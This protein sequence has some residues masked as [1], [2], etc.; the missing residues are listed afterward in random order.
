[1]IMKQIFQVIFTAFLFVFA[2][3]LVSAC[4]GEDEFW[5][6]GDQQLT[7]ESH[8]NL[9]NNRVVA[10]GTVRDVRFTS[11]TI[12]CSANYNYKESLGIKPSIIYSTSPNR[13]MCGDPY[14]TQIEVKDFTKSEC[15]VNLDNLNPGT[16]YYYR[17]YA[18]A[19]GSEHY[20]DLK[21]FTTPFDYSKI[22]SV[23][24]GLSVKWAIHNIGA[25]QPEELGKYFYWGQTSA[26]TSKDWHD[27]ALSTLVSHGYID[28]NNNL[29]PSYDTATELWGG[30]W[31]MPTKDEF[32]ELI[33][34]CEWKRVMKNGEEVALITGPNGN[35]IYMPRTGS[36][37]SYWTSSCSSSKA[38]YFE[39]K[40]SLGIFYNYN[41]RIIEN[42][43]A[44]NGC[45]RPIM[46]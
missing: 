25:S 26:S 4:E 23:D 31:R 11:A 3:V 39:W 6:A 12:L 1:M 15:E 43:R 30:K 36:V 21:S 10:T 44:D 8:G 14:T 29:C 2:G 20:G 7:D 17:A 33:D 46:K 40:A 9:R 34:K 41:R 32:Q 19:D 27:F 16:T 45:I 24:L 28:N 35:F 22:E 13:P 37:F 18:I 38:Y 5:D 42:Y